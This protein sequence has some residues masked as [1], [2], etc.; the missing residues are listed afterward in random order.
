LDTELPGERFYLGSPQPTVCRRMRS[1]QEIET[2]KPGF[3]GAPV[4]EK[5]MQW[6]DGK[7]L[8]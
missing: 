2:R 5:E 1:V 8:E 6:R 4:Q 3:L 7:C